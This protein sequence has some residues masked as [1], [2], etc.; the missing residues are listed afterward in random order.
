M[1]DKITEALSY[2]GTET[3]VGMVCEFKYEDAMLKT[4]RH[5]EDM[6]FRVR[7]GDY[8]SHEVNRYYVKVLGYK[9]VR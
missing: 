7:R 4:A 3:K 9:K 8:G 6:G 1:A 5:L 2:K